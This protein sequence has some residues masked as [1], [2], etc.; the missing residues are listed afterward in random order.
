M[1]P[2]IRSLLISTIPSL[3]YKEGTA[4][5]HSAPGL[6]TSP[7]QAAP[8]AP[9]HRTSPSRDGYLGTSLTTSHSP[10]AHLLW[11]K[12][13][14]MQIGRALGQTPLPPHTSNN[15]SYSM[16]HTLR[17][18]TPTA[19]WLSPHKSFGRWTR[20]WRASLGESR[21]YPHSSRRLSSTPSL[22]TSASISP[23]SGRINARRLYDLKLRFST[24]EAP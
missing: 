11:A 16:A 23:Q 14:I 9:L 13:Q 3:S 8:S 1:S 22:R 18:H 6:L 2:N 19:S 12:S 15:A 10:E 5:T 7:S 20:C 24:M 4:T 21:T 17:A